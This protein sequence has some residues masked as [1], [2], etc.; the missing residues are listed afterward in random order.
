MPSPS[1]NFTPGTV[2]TSA[3]ANAVDRNLFEDVIDV[4]DWGAVG[5]G[6]TDDAAA[7]QAALNAVDANVG[8]VVEFPPGRYIIGTAIEITRN[9]TTLRG[10]RGA[11][12]KFKNNS[13]GTLPYG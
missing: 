9:N 3:W 7:I 2:V 4:K 12:I 13:V 1:I 10:T 5:D 11:I 6:V 8:G